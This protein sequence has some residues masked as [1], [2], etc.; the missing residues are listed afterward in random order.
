MPRAPSSRRLSRKA[1]RTSQ[2]AL[3]GWSFSSKL[4]FGGSAL[5]SHP[6]TARPIATQS[7][8]HLV[9]R[10]TQATGA[11]SFLKRAR[12]VE[13]LVKQQAT[14]VGIRVYDFANAGNHLHMVVRV[15]SRRIYRRFV[16]AVTGLLARK[17]LG[18]ERGV[19]VTGASSVKTKSS[20][21]MPSNEMSAKRGRQPTREAPPPST[22]FWDARPFSRVVTWG[23]DYAQV[24]NYLCLNRIEAVG[25]GRLD[26]RRLLARGN[27]F[28]GNSS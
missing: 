2:L 1:S 19:A 4:A 3:P 24:K 18:K 8:L 25:F 13:K 6:K 14:R 22:R 17:T 23:K 15:P 20:S 27:L 28:E 26:A 10:S 16:R 21:P 11:R 5:T 9:L 7:A 12:E